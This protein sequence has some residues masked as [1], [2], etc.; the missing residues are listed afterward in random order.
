MLVLLVPKFPSLAGVVAELI[1][2]VNEDYSEKLTAKAAAAL[3]IFAADTNA[4]RKKK[5]GTSGNCSLTSDYVEAL[6][7]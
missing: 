7:C 1:S 6:W 4:A 3:A 5:A 2:L